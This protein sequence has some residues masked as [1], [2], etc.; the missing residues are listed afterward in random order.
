MF[1]SEDRLCVS[2]LLIIK[3]S[4]NRVNMKVCG[5]FVKLKFFVYTKPPLVLFTMSLAILALGTACISMYIKKTDLTV[6]NASKV[7]LVLLHGCVKHEVNPFHLLIKYQEI[8]FN[9][10]MILNHFVS[11]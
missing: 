6:D 5:A 1:S 11:L 10:C 4:L 9:I 7:R 2:F 8:S 3:E